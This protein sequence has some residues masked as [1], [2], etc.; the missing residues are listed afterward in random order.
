M[1]EVRVCLA[2]AVAEHTTMTSFARR[3]NVNK[4]NLRNVLAGLRQPQREHLA[5]LGVRRVITFEQA[6]APR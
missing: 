6:R 3:Y 2:L 4:G 5:I 1:E